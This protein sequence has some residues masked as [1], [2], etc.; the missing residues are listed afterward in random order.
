MIEFK[1]RIQDFFNLEDDEQKS[2]YL[3]DEFMAN[4]K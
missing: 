1:N 4:I 2:A 3:I